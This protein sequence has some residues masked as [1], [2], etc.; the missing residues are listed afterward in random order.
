MF[1]YSNLK[2]STPSVCMGDVGQA[3]FNAFSVWEA[4]V[5]LRRCQDAPW[6]SNRAAC[7]LE[8]RLGKKDWS[9]R[10]FDNLNR[11]LFAGDPEVRIL[12]YGKEQMWKQIFT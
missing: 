2:D 9:A 8:S 7:A 1:L 3:I 5:R 11:P 10:S 4:C 12:G 6:T